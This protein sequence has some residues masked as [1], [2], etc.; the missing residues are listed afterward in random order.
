M[1]CDETKPACRRCTEKQTVC[2]GYG[3]NIRWS[4]KH[5]FLHQQTRQ[6]RRK[7]HDASKDDNLI[8]HQHKVVE[9][10]QENPVAAYPT[11]QANVYAMRDGP[12]D[13]ESNTTDTIDLDSWAHLDIFPSIELQTDSI[14]E[15]SPMNP[16]QSSM[17]NFLQSETIGLDD[18]IEPI[19]DQI[20]FLQ[21]STREMGT[22]TACS[23]ASREEEFHETQ[24]PE[25]LHVQTQS[26]LLDDLSGTFSSQQ[27]FTGMISTGLELAAKLVVLPKMPISRKIGTIPEM[28]VPHFFKEIVPL[29]SCFDSEL[30]SI[31]VLF[32]RLWQSSEPLFHLMQSMSAACLVEQFPHMGPIAVK[33]YCDS[34]RS[35]Q[36]ILGGKEAGADTS[37]ALILLGQTA[38]WHQPTNLAPACHRAATSAVKETYKAAH[39]DLDFFIPALDYWGMLLAFLTDEFE[40]QSSHD[41][42]SMSPPRVLPHPFSGTS[43]AT[44]RTLSHI[45]SLI[46]R[47]KKQISSMI[48]MTEADI[49]AFRRALAEAQTLEEAL[50]LYQAKEC[51]WLSGTG[52]ERTN[53]K[54]L[55]NIDEAYRCVGLLQLYRVFPDLLIRRYRPWSKD[56][57]LN[58]PE[59]SKIPTPMERGHWLTCLALHTIELL[60]AIDF[61]SRTRCV[62]PFILVATSSELQ[63]VTQQSQN[64]A[65]NDISEFDLS[66]AAARQFIRVRLSA[67]THIL[68]LRKVR[69]IN[70]LISAIWEE[71]DAGNKNAYWLDVALKKNMATMMG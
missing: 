55:K 53:L 41:P 48:F 58:P 40:L 14:H 60:R 11:T 69:V 2:P 12:E 32:Q 44:V 47:Y 20:E 34:W 63:F 51:Y 8:L 43:H 9:N 61:S 62:Q 23:E 45:G 65:S 22:Q 38:S 27:P 46:L 13:M 42:N 36:N 66:I 3:S 59:P 57:L 24:K 6:S 29:Y 64:E 33:E 7:Q 67:Y 39:Q 31:R 54:D 52:D 25:I 18:I 68:P 70:D 30:S 10:C 71:I 4:R 37:L 5:E 19:S 21:E 49:R 1:K 15:L 35:L 28:L 16:L 56:E 17:E 26:H 50:L